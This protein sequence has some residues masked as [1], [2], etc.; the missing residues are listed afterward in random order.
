MKA[1]PKRPHAVKQ[2]VKNKQSFSEHF[3]SLL[4]RFSAMEFSKI[5]FIFDASVALIVLVF[6]LAIMWKTENI[7]PLSTLITVVF[8]ALAAGEGFY[9]NK[10]K[11]ENKI[12]L[13]KENGIKPTE[14]TFIDDFFE[15]EE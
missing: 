3:K 7:D 9:Y 6:S 5:I 1:P 12:K 11:A 10:A 15:S 2:E 8:G 4:L 13:M 14:K